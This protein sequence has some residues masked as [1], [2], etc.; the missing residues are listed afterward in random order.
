MKYY[1]CVI[2]PC[3]SGFGEFEMGEVGTVG[4]DLQSDLLSAAEDNG[5]SAYLLDDPSRPAE[6]EDIRGRIRGEEGDIFGW[7][8]VGDD[9]PSPRYFAVVDRE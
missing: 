1:E 4:W 7:I 8:V 5:V 6:I 9:G 3:S 2:H